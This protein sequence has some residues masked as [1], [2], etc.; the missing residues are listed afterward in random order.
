MKSIFSSVNTYYKEHKRSFAWRDCGNPYYVFVSEVM[1]QQT[2]THRVAPKFDFFISLF[3]DVHAL[4]AAPLSAVLSAWQ[5]LGYNRRARFLHKA[6]QEIVAA[7]SGIIPRDPALLVLLPGIGAAT[8]ASISAFAYNEPTVFIETNIRA[9]FLHFFFPAEEKV[10]DK[11]LLPL[12]RASLQGQDPRQWYYALMDYGVMLK[13]TVP[14]PSRKSKHHTK[15]SAFKGSTREVRG[16]II[17]VLSGKGHCE[18]VYSLQ[19]AVCNDIERV[20]SVALFNRIIDSLVKEGL[21][22]VV[23]GLYSLPQHHFFKE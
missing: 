4:A 16:A 10:D 14:N 22:S 9:V 21:V 19:E 20:V 6:A 15:Q 3:P 23:N 17:R 1:L 7:Y 13:K 2:Q 5:G 18:N 12:V 11:V 8:A